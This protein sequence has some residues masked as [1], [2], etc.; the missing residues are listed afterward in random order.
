VGLTEN[1]GG[2]LGGENAAAA[3]HIFTV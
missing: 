2:V 1:G 3:V